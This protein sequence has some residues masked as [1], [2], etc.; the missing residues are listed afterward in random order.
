VWSQTIKAIEPAGM[1]LGALMEAQRPA[2]RASSD[3][4]ETF[5]GWLAGHVTTEQI[6]K[7][8]AR[9]LRENP[10]LADPS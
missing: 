7:D 5:T 6:R 1:D 3:M 2:H 4:V 9:I 10:E 8:G